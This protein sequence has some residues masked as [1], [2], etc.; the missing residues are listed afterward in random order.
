M[1]TMVIMYTQCLLRK[2]NT[3]QVAYIPSKFA[4]LNKI[5]KISGDNGWIVIQIGQ[6]TDVVPNIRKAIKE[7]RKSTGDSLPK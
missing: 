5:L 1:G 7:H 6:C 2:N 4:K 3:E